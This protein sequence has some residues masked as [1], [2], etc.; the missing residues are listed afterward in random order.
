MINLRSKQRGAFSIEFALL[1]V[2]FSTM[3]IFTADLVVKL[4]VQG[5]MDRLSYSLVNI[6]KERTQLYGKDNYDIDQAM[7][8]D[9]YSVARSSLNRTLGGYDSANFGGEFEL[10]QFDFEGNASVSTIEQ[11]RGC[12]LDQTISQMQDLSMVTS[13][14]RRA[15]LY[16]VTLCYETEN[17][18]GDLFDEDFTTIQSS[19]IMMGR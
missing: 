7:V 15:T 13:W 5:K 16:R 8:A 17:W 1:G 4:S 19:S 3:L 11:G 10:L 6:I 2:V 18:A 12:Q 9:I 14:G